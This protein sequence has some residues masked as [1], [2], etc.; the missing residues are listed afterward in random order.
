M[1]TNKQEERRTKSLTIANPMYDTVFK[2]LMENDRV[3]KFFIGTLLEEEVLSVDIRPQEYT[4]KSDG[5]SKKNDDDDNS[6]AGLAYSIYRVDFVAVVKTKEGE[7]KKILIEVQKGK[8]EDDVMRFR[9]YLGDQYKKTDKVDGKTMVLPIITIYILGF[10]LSRMDS[11]CVKVNRTYVDMLNH[12]T[13]DVKTPFLEKLTHDTYVIQT[14]K[15]SLPH[16]R[17]KLEQLLGI[18]E[19]AHFTDE[20]SEIL[21]RYRQSDDDNKDIQLITS[22]LHEMGTDPDERKKI[23]DE[24]EALRT[25]EELYGRKIRAAKEANEEI[26]KANEEQVKVIKAQAKA[27][28]ETRKANEEKDKRIAELERILKSKHE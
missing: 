28:E 6:I 24:V 17:T 5:A 7:H 23:E 20:N 3:V 12:Q 8:D 15:I 21:K 13:I 14:K 22:I 25:W 18:F 11:P 10:N 9:N 4:H 26:A 27:L 2:R 16:Y 1:N 19:Q